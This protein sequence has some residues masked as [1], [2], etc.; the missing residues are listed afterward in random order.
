MNKNISVLVVLM[1]LI[2]AVIYQ[3]VSARGKETLK[4][5]QAIAQQ[6]A[7]KPGFL[8]PAF[9]IA[10]K[11]GKTYTVGGKR[12]KPLMLNFG[13]SW[14]GPCELEAPDLKNVYEKYIDDFDLYGINTTDQDNLADAEK[15]VK[16]YKLPF[17]SLF[18]KDG[19]I[20]KQFHFSGIPTSFL[21]DRNGVVVEVIRGVLSPKELERKIQTLIQG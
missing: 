10:G 7:S 17:P 18:D 9:E 21:I 13:A 5:E 16:L 4:K 8:A 6:T 19:K 14:C 2:G 1:V 3:N 20:A 15:F 11:D 12:E